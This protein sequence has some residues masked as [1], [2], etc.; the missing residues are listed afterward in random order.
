LPTQFSEAASAAAT[1]TEERCQNF[2]VGFYLHGG[3]ALGL[4]HGLVWSGLVWAGVTNQKI[5]K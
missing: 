1:A 4:V 2:A 5:K 3:I